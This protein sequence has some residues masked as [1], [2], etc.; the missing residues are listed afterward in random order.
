MFSRPVAVFP[1]PSHSRGEERFKAIGRSDAGRHIFVVFT[2]R[3]RDGNPFI[4]PIG[5]RY[6]HRKEIDHYE[7]E[8]AEAQ[9][10]SW[11]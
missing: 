8:A 7:K 3:T 11:G 4:R 10:R 2:L 9:N 1:D 5:A 6:M